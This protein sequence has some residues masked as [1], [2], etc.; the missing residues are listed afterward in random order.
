MRIA[1]PDTH[2]HE[3]KHCGLNP[4]TAGAMQWTD[5]LP[6]RPG[7][8]WI[9]RA[10]LRHNAGAWHEVNP[11][12]MEVTEDKN[13]TLGLSMSGLDQVW[14]LDDVIVAEWAGQLRPLAE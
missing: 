4:P 3:L 11:V 14:R 13:G 5:E 12:L 1:M 8:Y 9:R 2:E 7:W 10:V 6:T